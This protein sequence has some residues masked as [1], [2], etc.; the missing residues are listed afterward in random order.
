MGKMKPP[1]D[2]ERKIDAILCSAAPITPQIAALI[3]RRER[4][5]QNAVWESAKSMQ[6]AAVETASK[7]YRDSGWH[8]H[9]RVAGQ[10][11]AKLIEKIDPY[12]PKAE[13]KQPEPELIN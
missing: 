5:A 11:I 2:L 6:K 1:D 12:E 10:H 7:A 13:I 4:T 3:R 9:M 8:P